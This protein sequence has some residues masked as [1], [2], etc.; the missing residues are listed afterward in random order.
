MIGERPCKI[1]DIVVHDH[2][3]KEQY[4]KII[5]RANDIFTHTPHEV[6]YDRDEEISVPSIREAHYNLTYMEKISGYMLLIND[7]GHVKDDLKIPPTDL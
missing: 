5:I 6:V 3:K 2:S 1:T 4:H 7:E